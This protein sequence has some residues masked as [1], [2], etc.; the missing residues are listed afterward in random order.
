MTC[1]SAAR[2][3][4]T[5]RTDAGEWFEL[6]NEDWTERAR[7]GAERARSDGSVRCGAGGSGARA[8]RRRQLSD[9]GRRQASQRTPA[10]AVTLAVAGS[11]SHAT[12]H[13]QLRGAGAD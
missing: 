7:P 3:V 10:Y 1:R 13:V 8:G 11:E 4:D 6:G 5:E 2:G 9:A 12:G